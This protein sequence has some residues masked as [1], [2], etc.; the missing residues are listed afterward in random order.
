MAYEFLADG[1]GCVSAESVILGQTSSRG[2]HFPPSDIPAPARRTFSMNW[3]R[4]QPDIGYVPVP[5]VPEGNPVTGGPLDMSF[6]VPA[7]S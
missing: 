5:M 3:I 1:S 7:R 2:Q 6:A 4:H